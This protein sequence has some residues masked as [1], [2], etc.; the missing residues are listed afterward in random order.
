[1]DATDQW[2][3]RFLPPR[4]F[5]DYRS[6]GPNVKKPTL[7][8]VPGPRPSIVLCPLRASAL[9]L[10]SSFS[11]SPDRALRPRY[12]RRRRGGVS[13]RWEPS[14]QRSSTS[15]SSAT[16]RNPV[17]TSIYPFVLRFD[18]IRSTESGMPSLFV[19]I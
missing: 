2:V 12:R 11:P 7:K 5:G 13:R 10:S 6:C 8:P 19:R 18:L 4:P 15:S 9:L 17:R 3:G 1:M 16:S 14:P